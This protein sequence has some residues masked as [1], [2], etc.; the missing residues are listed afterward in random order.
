MNG[1]QRPMKPRFHQNKVMFTEDN[2]NQ[3]IDANMADGHYSLQEA[4]TRL[5]SEFKNIDAVR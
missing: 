5:H 3:K 4:H 2:R 1:V